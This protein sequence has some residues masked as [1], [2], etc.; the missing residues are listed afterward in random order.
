M[1]A[2]ISRIVNHAL[3]RKSLIYTIA[4]AVNKAIPFLILPFLTYYLTPAD[5][6]IVSNYTIYISILVIVIG[7]NLNGA[8]SAN[9]FKMDKHAISDY[10]ANIILLSFICTV[11]CT[12]IAL[13][14]LPYLNTL[15]S[16]TSFFSVIAIWLAFCQSISTINTDLWR[17]E[18]KPVQFGVYQILQTITNVVFTVLLV[19]VIRYGWKGRLWA[20]VFTYMAFAIA[21]IAILYKRGF[22]HIKIN[23]HYIK[24]AL[25]FGLPLIPHSLGLWIRLSIDRV[26]ITKFYGNAA[27]G[28]Y[29]AGIQF[30]LLLSF[31]ILA[32]Q[33][34]YV[35]YLYKRLAANDPNTK[36]SLVKFTYFYF[37]SV[38]ALAGFFSIAAIFVIQHFLS[39][40]YKEASSYV[41]WAM[42]SQAFQGMYM[43][44]GI[45][46]FYAKKTVVIAFVTFSVALLQ[47]LASYFLIK[48]LGPI[49]GAYSALL[50]SVVN[51]ALMWIASSKVFPM[52]WFSLKKL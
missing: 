42:F 10:S 1:K 25:K 29:A 20:L 50:L 8:L 17:L 43:V 15:L 16:I 46:L 7:L 31:L 27:A 26:F 38:L 21:S 48:T 28:L 24:D 9:Y 40:H 3:F 34:A 49:G 37:I 52:P 22:L 13:F 41:V 39:V 51:F 4:D 45:Y 19:I 44:V 36:P 11:L 47:L 35:P 33:N 30:G 32:F 14:T 5:Y 18:E 2:Y 12:I 6:G 23:K